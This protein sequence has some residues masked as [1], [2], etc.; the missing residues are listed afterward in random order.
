MSVSADSLFFELAPEEYQ[1]S[2]I[3]S[4]SNYFLDPAKCHEKILNVG[5]HLSNSPRL[6]TR[7]KTNFSIR[8]ALV[9]RHVPI[10][11]D[12]CAVKR[13]DSDLFYFS[14]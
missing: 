1:K 6:S 14:G 2:S 8:L 4:L 12:L 11:N 9:S 3:H 13:L 10:L 5:V 7:F